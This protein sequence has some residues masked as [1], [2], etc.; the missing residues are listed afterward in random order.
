MHPVATALNNIS[1]ELNTQFLQR[2]DTIEAAIL[3]LL[4]KQHAFILGPP[5]TAKSELIRALVQRILNASYY[6][7][8]LS[9]TRPDAAVLGPYNLPELRDK[10]E[11]K[12]KMDGFLPTVN[13]AM[14]DEI[15]KMSPILGHDLLSVLNERIIH[16]VNGGRSAHPVPLYTCWTAS[17]EL[18]TDDSEDAAALWDRLLVRCTVDYL[19]ETSDFVKLL[20]LQP[21]PIKATVEWA[22]LADAIDNDVPTITLDRSAIDA[23]V[24]LRKA[25]DDHG[26]RPSDRRWRQSVR[27]LQASAFLNGRSD[28][29]DDDLAALRFT[30][31]DNAEQI[32]TVERTATSI[33]NPL[34]EKL[35]TYRDQLAEISSGVKAREGKAME[36]R[37]NYAIDAN[38]K[39]KT[40]GSDLAR[41]EQECKQQG[42]STTR[43]DV[44]MDQRQQVQTDVYV[45]MLDMDPAR[46]PSR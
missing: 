42:R 23:I 36:E 21:A 45:K 14:L 20:Q 13:L 22:T 37:A 40:I 19:E 44:V 43:V 11:Y 4:S 25:L 7:T 41:L 15:G 6:E 33:A 30:L 46:L 16:E 27:V 26:I 38:K 39:L 5:G 18:F 8:T 24:K 12:R 28:V 9:R 2:R 35:N 32:H 31:W 3:A 17:N 34:V 1:A 10:G 29:T